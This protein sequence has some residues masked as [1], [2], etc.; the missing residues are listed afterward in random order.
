MINLDQYT[1][2]G[3]QARSQLAR[4]NEILS[5]MQDIGGNSKEW[6]SQIEAAIKSKDLNAINSSYDSLFKAYND[7][8][9]FVQKAGKAS[10]EEDNAGYKSPAAASE[11]I[12]SSL[13]LSEERGIEI[14]DSLIEDA[15]V[16]TVSNDV[17]YMNTVAKN[18]GDL[19]NPIIRQQTEENKRPEQTTDGVQIIG[20]TTRTRYTQTGSPISSGPVNT[21]RFNVVA[22]QYS[23]APDQAATPSLTATYDPAAYGGQALPPTSQAM[24]MQVTKDAE[25]RETI[26]F[27]PGVGTG[28]GPQIKVAEGQ[29][30]E[31]DEGGQPI[32]IKDIPGGKA[33]EEKITAERAKLA[34]TKE[35]KRKGG[36]ILTELDRLVG[37]AEEM[38]TMPGASVARR[39]GLI[40]G[41]ERP[42]EVENTIA[43]IRSNLQ[44]DTIR[45]LR[46]NSPTGSTGLGQVTEKEFEALGST[47]GAL[48]Q[49]GDPKALKERSLRFKKKFLDLVHGSR[50][51]RQKALKEG[52]ITREA[53]E[54]VEALYPGYEPKGPIDPNIENLRSKYNLD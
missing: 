8:L 11:G 46:N 2:P 53:N 27:G 4:V 12:I 40:T 31:Y 13:R 14:P 45:E 24:G 49:V 9:T 18:I 36:I 39:V 35:A 6:Q 44:F 54:A 41:F 47:E 34:E 50:E 52:K 23:Q 51:E 33:A 48:S 38:S 22:Q 16:A 10:K 29:M 37:F 30:V 1:A 5:Q 19:V 17:D 28:R 20:E 26:T 15:Y 7:R 25:G 3:S 43:S 42:S 32:R 21:D